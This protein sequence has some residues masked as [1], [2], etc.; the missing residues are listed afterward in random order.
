MNGRIFAGIVIL[1]GSLFSGSC[2]TADVRKEQACPMYG[3]LHLDFPG[4]KNV[5][6]E[7]R[8][9]IVTVVSVDDVTQAKK[10]DNKEASD[11]FLK[12]Y[13]SICGQEPPFYYEIA[14][15]KRMTAQVTVG[16]GALLASIRD[17]N[18]QK[19]SS[20]FSKCKYLGEV[21]SDAKILTFPDL[22]NQAGEIGANLF[23]SDGENEH[24][25]IA[26]RCDDLNG[27]LAA[28]KEID[29]KKAR[30]QEVQTAKEAREREEIDARE[31]KQRKQEELAAKEKRGKELYSKPHH[32]L[33]CGATGYSNMPPS[34]TQEMLKQFKLEVFDENGKCED[35]AFLKN[36]MGQ[37]MG[38]GCTCKF[39]KVDRQK[40][41]SLVGKERM[42]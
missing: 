32:W 38:I 11:E 21:V 29:L 9:G 35:T 18:K 34:V 22:R 13:K 31:A 14:Y 39:Q 20:V 2:S 33:Y 36:Q 16:N 7:G 41:E 25:G 17:E 26:Y 6:V 12:S 3:D 40:A 23:F 37:Q 4:K 27:I 1:G 19:R 8:G 15:V 5:T 10:I 28:Q 42:P 30:E 24:K